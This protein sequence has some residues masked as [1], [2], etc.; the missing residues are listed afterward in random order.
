VISGVAVSMIAF[1]Y[2]RGGFDLVLITTAALA[3]G[4]VAAVVA[5][6]VLVNSV[7]REKRAVQPA[8]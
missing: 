1:L 7:E 3:L 6:A 5:I 8:E 2:A 4:F